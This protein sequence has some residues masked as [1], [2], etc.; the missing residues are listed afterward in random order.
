TANT[1]TAGPRG[2]DSGKWTTPTATARGC[3][4]PV[5]LT[6]EITDVDTATGE[7]IRRVATAD[8]P[9]GVLYVPCGTR[10]ASLCPSCAETY[11]RDAYQIVKSVIDGGKGIPADEAGR[12]SVFFTFTATSFGLVHT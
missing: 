2:N 10:R 9:D 12:L 7:I 6:G 11:R 3:S 4:H 5:R 1:L 8:M